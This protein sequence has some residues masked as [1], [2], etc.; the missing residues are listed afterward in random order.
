MGE[1]VIK[2]STFSIPP[3]SELRSASHLKGEAVEFVKLEQV[4]ASLSRGEW[5]FSSVMSKG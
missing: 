2:F 4:T 5:F 1:G 3:S